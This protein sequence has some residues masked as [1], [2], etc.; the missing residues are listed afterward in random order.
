MQQMTAKKIFS[1]WPEV[2][3]KMVV[4][5]M[6]NDFQSEQWYKCSEFVKSCVQIQARNIPQDHWEDIVQE[7][8]IQISKYLEAFRYQ[9]KLRTWLVSIVRSCIIDFHRKFKR[10]EQCIAS[11]DN[12][13]SNSENEDDKFA[14]KTSRTLED[15]YLIYDELGKALVALQEYLS[16]HANSVRN[17]Q[18]LD[19]VIFEGQSLEIAAQ[20]VGCSAPVAGHVVRSAQRYARERLGYQR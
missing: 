20:A 1:V 13:L 8:M 17:G 15:E 10:T 4:E 11:P 7:A 3:D 6:L 19:I 9:C 16:I 2:N 12:V 18:I 14:I 5:E